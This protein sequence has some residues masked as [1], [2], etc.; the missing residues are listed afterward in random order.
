MAW[1]SNLSM[2]FWS[3]QFALLNPVLAVLLTT[4]FGASGS[5]AGV[6][7]AISNAAGLVA[8]TVI[9]AAADRHGKY[10]T[11]MVCSALCGIAFVGVL[12]ATESLV[13]AA[14][15]MALLGAPTSVGATLLFAQ[16]RHVGAA[17]DA[18][19]R[20]RAV[21][22][23]AWVVGPPLS[24]LITSVAPGR[25]VLLLIGGIGLVNLLTS[26]LA[27][28]SARV[29]SGIRSRPAR[30]EGASVRVRD[31]FRAPRV[32][33]AMA[34]FVTLQTLNIAAGTTMGL[35]VSTELRAPLPWAGAALGLAAL[36]EIP[37]LVV[38]GRL[39]RV[40]SA[41]ALVLS[42]ASV[43]A[44]YYLAVA[45][46]ESPVV[47]VLLQPLNAWFFATVAGVGLTTFQDMIPAPG[48]ATGAFANT[49]QVAAVL[50]GGFIALVAGRPGGY[51][52]LY[53]ICAGTAGLVAVSLI[54]RV[55]WRRGRCAGPPLSRSASARQGGRLG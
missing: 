2:W 30:S 26:T 32:W 33:A 49:G 29:R 5:E 21:V 28:R 25:T 22:S 51:D 39:L 45:L 17:P 42:G 9:P 31:A 12:L 20:T 1:S 11:G 55:G 47:L 50:S 27:S 46:V 10:V 16:L 34:V 37:A 52:T 14:A 13:V 35:F 7:L 53:W 24:T 36:A 15:S 44:A 40:W 54:V 18:L 48:L 19:V 23:F 8:S 4:V 38:L 6:V 41:H 43:G 3:L